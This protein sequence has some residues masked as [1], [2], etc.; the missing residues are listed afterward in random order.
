MTPDIAII[1]VNWN[2]GEY[3]RRSLASVEQFAPRMNYEIIVV[4]NASTDGSREWLSSLGTRIHLIAN[5]ENVGFGKA[6]NQAF[7]ATAAPLLFMLNSDAEVSP[8]A[9]ERLVATIMEEDRIAAVG[10]RLLNTDGSLQPS[11]WRNPLTPFEMIATSLSLYH[12]MPRRLRGKL[13]LGFHWDHSERRQAPMLSGAAL[14]VKREV[15][16]DVGGFDESFHMYGEDNEW[17]LRIVRGGWPSPR[18]D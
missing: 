7:A 12:L 3:L 8:G 4:D 1:I 15:I 9:I 2:G 5:N 10:P 13:L 18:G 6:N 11:V 14:L 17:A 16:D